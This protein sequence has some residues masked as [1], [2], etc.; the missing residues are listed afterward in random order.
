MDG[1]KDLSTTAAYRISSPTIL[2]VRPAH[3]KSLCD[4]ILHQ[5]TKSSW[6]LTNLAWRHKL[7]GIL[8]G[9]IT[10][11]SLWDRLVYDSARVKVMGKGAGTVRAVVVSGGAFDE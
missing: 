7:S 11:Q 9:Y 3:L 8:E 4:N 10:K 1:L 6:I 5:A 2:F